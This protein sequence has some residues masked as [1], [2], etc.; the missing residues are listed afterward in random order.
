MTFT[1][2]DNQL[3][4][5]VQLPLASD[6]FMS[7]I[8]RYQLVYTRISHKFLLVKFATLDLLSS[9]ISFFFFHFLLFYLIIFLSTISV[10]KDAYI[11]KL[12]SKAL[13]MARVKWI[14]QFYLPPTRLSTNGISY[15]VFTP[16]RTASPHVGRYSLPD[17]QRVGG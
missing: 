9:I 2:C 14:T 5:L 16:S 11:M 15:P 1:S 10:N 8:V 7:I 4:K 13:N 12:I 6:F 3:H 17:P